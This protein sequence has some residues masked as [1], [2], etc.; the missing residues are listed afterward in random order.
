MAFSL[1][2]GFLTDLRIKDGWTLFIESPLW[3]NRDLSGNLVNI[4][5]MRILRWGFNCGILMKVNG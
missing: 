3:D 1:G 5:L 4:T 2:K